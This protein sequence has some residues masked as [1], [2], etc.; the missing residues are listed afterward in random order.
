MHQKS[1]SFRDAV[2]ELGSLYQIDIEI[3]NEDKKIKQDNEQFTLNVEELQ[4]NLKKQFFELTDSPIKKFLSDYLSEIGYL[5]HLNQIHEFSTDLVAKVPSHIDDKTDFY[6]IPFQNERNKIL[7]FLC[8]K[9]DMETTL[10]VPYSKYEF[11]IFFSD[12][13]QEHLVINFPQARKHSLNK[14]FVIATNSLDFFYCLKQ[15]LH[16]VLLTNENNLSKKLYYFFSKFVLNL[17]IIISEDVKHIPE[18]DKQPVL[19][20]RWVKKIFFEKI[21][22]YQSLQGD[23]F[24]DWIFGAKKLKV[25]RK[26]N[27][28]TSQCFAKL[29]KTKKKEIQILEKTSSFYHRILLHP[30]SQHVVQ[31]LNA[32][33]LDINDINEWNIGFC[34]RESILTRALLK[35]NNDLSVF[36]ELGLLRLSQ[37]KNQYYDFFYDRFVIPILN[38][39]GECVALGGRILDDFQKVPKYINSAE[40]ILFSKSKILFNFYRA[41]ESIIEN[42]YVIIVEGYMDCIT[43]FKHGVCNVVAVMGTALT[44]EHLLSLSQITKRVLL[45]FDSDVAGKLAIKKSFLSNLRFPNLILEVIEIPFEK[46]PDEYVKNYGIESFLT[47]V[48]NHTVIIYDYV[49]KMIQQKSR[50]IDDFVVNMQEEFK[51]AELSVQSILGQEFKNYLSDTYAIKM[52][53]IFGKKGHNVSLILNS[54]IISNIPAWSIKNILEIK[55]LFAF[56]Y[57]PFEVMPKKILNIFVQQSN[58][59]QQNNEQNFELF[60]QAYENQIS[61]E[62]K[63]ILSDLFFQAQKQKY[64]SCNDLTIHDIADLH[65]VSKVF[66]AYIKKFSSII[67]SIGADFLLDLNFHPQQKNNSFDFNQVFQSKNV[68]FLRI[69][70]KSIDL[71]IKHHKLVQVF[72]ELLLQLEL[73]EIDSKLEAYSKTHFNQ[74]LQDSFNN[75]LHERE[76]RRVLLMS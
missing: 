33:G 49:T 56:F 8:L 76:I 19:F 35:E 44:V 39:T 16:N 13:Q 29:T 41:S 68:Q 3:E 53:N 64:L 66:V 11:S 23:L 72:V 75:L 74:N 38:H 52:E 48:K 57:C 54:K 60:Y 9:L 34:P 46:D 73:S 27:E 25:N 5:N 26:V 55:I 37:R 17:Y 14:S 58:Q 71:S 67:V 20:V 47:I 59:L 10:E 28:A 22:F 4:K 70:L 1:L 40:S 65:E 69:Q 15:G 42:G 51:S 61:V 43:L 21:K 32:R 30:S 7:G 45:C 63:I 31:Y 50:D 6:T 24:G 62:G 12:E 36:I 2:F 18:S